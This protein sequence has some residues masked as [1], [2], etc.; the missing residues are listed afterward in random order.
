MSNVGFFP[1]TVEHLCECFFVCACSKG[2]KKEISFLLLELHTAKV[3]FSRIEKKI[4]KN[5]IT[6]HC[7]IPSK[8]TLLTKEP[9]CAKKLP[10]K[11]ENFYSNLPIFGEGGER[12][13]KK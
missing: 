12:R 6:V 1:S 2:G 5:K 7:C 8:Y 11:V 13:K 4:K 10:Q 3:S 9:L